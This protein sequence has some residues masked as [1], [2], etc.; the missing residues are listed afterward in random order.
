MVRSYHLIANIKFSENKIWCICEWV[1]SQED[2]EEHKKLA[3]PLKSTAVNQ[4]MIK[5]GYKNRKEAS[6]EA[7]TREVGSLDHLL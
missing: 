1:G 3:P 4:W 7:A 2:F 5:Y 6:L